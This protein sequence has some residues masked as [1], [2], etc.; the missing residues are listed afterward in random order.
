VARVH[1][2]PY[3]SIIFSDEFLHRSPNSACTM[4]FWHFQGLV[5]VPGP[6]A[7]PGHAKPLKNL[8]LSSCFK[9]KDAGARVLRS[10][11]S[12]FEECFS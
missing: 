5:N 9:R 3:F 7:V 4:G 6:R 12:F 11:F 8:R 1:L 2:H 10:T